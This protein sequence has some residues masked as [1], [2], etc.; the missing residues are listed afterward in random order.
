MFSTLS[1]SKNPLNDCKNANAFIE[2]LNSKKQYIRDAI[3]Y[4]K[5]QKISKEEM[6]EAKKQYELAMNKF[7]FSDMENNDAV[8]Y[9]LT[10]AEINLSRLIKA[11][12]LYEQENFG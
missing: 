2:S 11:Q 5:P 7:E 12:K 4:V 1:Y 9:E 10:L 8:S 6:D 3:E